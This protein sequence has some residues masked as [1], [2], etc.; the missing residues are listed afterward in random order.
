MAEAWDSG[1]RDSVKKIPLLSVSTFPACWQQWQSSELAHARPVLD[2]HSENKGKAY[3]QF[4]DGADYCRSK[5]KRGMGQT[6]KRGLHTVIRQQP[7]TAISITCFIQHCNPCK[8][9][10][11]DARPRHDHSKAVL[12]DPR[13]CKHSSSTFSKTKPQTPTGSQSLPTGKEPSG[14]ADAGTSTTCSSMSLPLS[15]MC[16]RHIL[17]QRLR[18]GYLS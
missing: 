15:L 14:A 10:W 13:S 4:R 9:I 8:G 6:A 17:P 16:L 12:C 11:H 1:T 5:G 18:S 2:C 7:C 3:N